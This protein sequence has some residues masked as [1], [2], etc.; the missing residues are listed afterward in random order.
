MVIHL[1]FAPVSSPAHGSLSGTAPNLTYTPDTGYSGSDSF[2][3]IANDGSLDSAPATVSITVNPPG[4]V[5]VFWDD[6]ESSTG[7]DEDP[8]NSDDATTGFWEVANPE[9]TSSSG[10]IMQL[11]D[12]YSGS[13][14]LVTEGSAGSSVG[15]Y[16]IDN[17]ETSILSPEISL[18]AGRELTLSFY[19][20]LGHL[21]NGTTD[22]YLRVSVVGDT[23]QL[24][25]EEL[26]SG[27]YDAASWASF[28][29]DISAFAGQDVH[30]L[31]AAADAGSGSLIEA[32]V[33]D[34]LIEGVLTN[35]PPSADP[36]SVSTDEDTPVGITLTGSDPD[37]DPLSFAVAS[38]PSHGTLSGS[39]P[40]LTYTPDANFNGSDS[41]TFT[42]NDGQATSSP[43]A[44]D[45]TVNP[46]NDAPLADPQIGFNR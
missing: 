45:I 23:T 3:F 16:D 9:E 4:P 7:W 11:G 10:Y 24:V 5:T 26:G 46:V 28:S 29:T 44:V 2:D 1:S 13:Q 27:D 17:G 43:A 19:Y 42:V 39:A 8:Y 38:G 31:I 20:Y 22:D 18:P 25:L 37:G 33:D 30:I 15:T 41:F 36:Q 40:N 21:S 32:G 35:N 34:V 12:A 6:F 14:N